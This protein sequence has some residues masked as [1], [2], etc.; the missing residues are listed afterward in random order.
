MARKKPLGTTLVEAY[1]RELADA[2]AVDP[3]G[4]PITW[5]T[6]EAATL[7]LI[8]RHGNAITELEKSIAAHGYVQVSE[9]GRL[10]VNPAVAELRLTAGAL[11]PLLTRIEADPDPVQDQTAGD[12]STAARALSRARWTKTFG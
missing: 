12:R 3:E 1:N 5:S 11:A 8:G 7:E 4:G 10:T 6:D 9:S 2:N